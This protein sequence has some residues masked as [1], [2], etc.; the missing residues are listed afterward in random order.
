M[1][2]RVGH[3]PMWASCPCRHIT[4]VL[5]ELFSSYARSEAREGVIFCLGCLGLHYAKP[6]VQVSTVHRN[7][8]MQRVQRSFP[9]RRIERRFQ[10]Y[11]AT[12][13]LQ[14]LQW[15]NTTLR[16]DRSDRAA[17]VQP[18]RCSLHSAGT[19]EACTC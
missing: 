15:F 8:R 19:L 14:W 9:K 7:P 13:R 5:K 17:A 10:K 16:F 3:E 4:R 1:T 11:T 12:P 2:A 6:K 18:I